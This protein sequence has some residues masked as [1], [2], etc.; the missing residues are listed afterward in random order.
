MMKLFQW[1]KGQEMKNGSMHTP[2]QEAR[3]Y[4][5]LVEAGA[6]DPKQ[7]EAIDAYIQE[8]QSELN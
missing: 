4:D 7:D 8:K 6:I 1:K 5:A 2:E 3:A